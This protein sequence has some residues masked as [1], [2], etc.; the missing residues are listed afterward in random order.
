MVAKGSCL[1]SLL[2]HRDLMR[3]PCC[4]DWPL[5]CRPCSAAVLAV[6][7]FFALRPGKGWL[8]RR[9]PAD[10]LAAAEASEHSS[11]DKPSS[12]KSSTFIWRQIHGSGGASNAATAGSSMYTASQ[13]LSS[14]PVL[15]FVSTHLVSL[16]QQQL[17]RSQSQLGRGGSTGAKPLGSP[18][19]N[20]QPS[21]TSLGG[22][23]SG[24]SA[25]WLVQWE[26]MRQDR[27]IGKGSYGRVYRA[28]L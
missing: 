20:R 14:D 6:L 10:G 27:L 3:R 1:S 21:E 25:Q 7:A 26:S 13:S 8:R 19:D 5:S 28:Y 9:A 16:R 11:P 4:H 18:S 12:I 15:M 23:L 24:D 22:G 2:L 17:L